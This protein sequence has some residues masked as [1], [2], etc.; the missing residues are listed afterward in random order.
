VRIDR[1]DHCADCPDWIS[2]GTQA[3][4]EPKCGGRDKNIY[5]KV[6]AEQIAFQKTLHLMILADQTF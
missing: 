1:W 6:N 3:E 5:R 2:V 4:H